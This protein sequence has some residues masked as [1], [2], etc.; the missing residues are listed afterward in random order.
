M[1]I[2]LFWVGLLLILSRIV[3]EYTGR[4]K[5]PPVIGVLLLGIFI[6][7]SGLRLLEDNAIFEFL[8]H[9]GILLLMFI[10]G[11]ETD[12]KQMLKTGKTAMLV[13]WLG[14]LVPFVSGILLSLFIH[15]GMGRMLFLATILTATSVSV[16]VITLL[17][18]NK[19]RTVPG[20]T[21]LGAAVLDDIIALIIIT[22][23]VSFTGKGGSPVF[24]F[25]KI[26]LYF[27]G[28]LLFG[29]YVIPYALRYFA[30]LKVRE[31]VLAAGIGFMLLYAFFAE[32]LG[33][34][35]VTGS[36][37][38]GILIGNTIEGRNIKRGVDTIGYGFFIPFFF[39][40]LGLM[41]AFHKLGSDVLFALVF[42]AIG[43]VSKFLGSGFG[44]YL[45]LRRVKESLSIGVGMM[46]RGE[47][48]LVVAALGIKEGL[49]TEADMTATIMLVV[50]SA[51][52]TPFILR[53]LMGG[54]DE[55]DKG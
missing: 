15:A 30:R 43:L 29:K 45:G 9:I 51:L 22:F 11:M 44:A 18:M 20:Y 47:V 33:I 25:L 46:P 1:L 41:A 32:K 27:T 23:I 6:G 21:I 16:T 7:P 42:V 13:A 54:K 10:A 34:A 14:V 5:I 26:L 2:Q 38:A 35:G 52:I 36:Y 19:L 39:V 8:S 37:L 3:S 28:A 40:Q 4:A 12:T 50:L 48:A 53:A 49:L 24:A 17:D 31:P 55:K